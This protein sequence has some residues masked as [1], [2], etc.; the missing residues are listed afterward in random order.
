MAEKQVNPRLIWT[1]SVVL[2]LLSGAI[3]VL[4][5]VKPQ[6]MGGPNASEQQLVLLR[7]LGAAF[8]VGAFLVLVPRV[9][10]LGALLLAVLLVGVIAWKD[11]CGLLPHRVMG[12][13]VTDIVEEPS[14]I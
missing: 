5:L 11:V 6:Q 4:L 2:A 14:K 12:R 1:A 3:G 9:A 13:V 10:W 7:A 8:C